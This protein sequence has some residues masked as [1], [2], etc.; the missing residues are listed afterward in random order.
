MFNSL[1]FPIVTGPDPVRPLCGS[2]TCV[3]VNHLWVHLE[4]VSQ[5]R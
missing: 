4:S 1:T 5:G 3:V 2:D